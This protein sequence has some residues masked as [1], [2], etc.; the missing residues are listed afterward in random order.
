M[1]KLALFVCAFVL[2]AGRPALMLADDNDN[3]AGRGKVLQFLT[4]SP[5]HGPF[6]GTQNPLRSLAGGGL[7]WV[8]SKVEGQLNQDGRVKVEVRGLVLADSDAVPAALRLTNPIP[9]FKAI[10]SCL[11]GDGSGQVSTINVSTGLFPASKA[12]DASIEDRVD[13][14]RECV[15]PIVFVTSPGSAWFAATGFGM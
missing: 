11:V 14:P 8:I 10:V 12:G 5:V 1:K 9:S 2:C 4:M 3:D 7:P 15:A 6:V 13:L